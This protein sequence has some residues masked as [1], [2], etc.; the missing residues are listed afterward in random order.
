MREEG[1]NLMV[2]GCR[3]NHL[4]TA[5]LAVGDVTAHREAEQARRRNEDH[6]RQAQ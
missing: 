3:I 5:L 1:R 2:G 4:K 6:L